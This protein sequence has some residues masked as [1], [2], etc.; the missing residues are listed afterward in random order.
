MNKKSTA[1]RSE[2]SNARKSSPD[3]NGEFGELPSV[4]EA[5]RRM[6]S[7]PGF[8]SSLS[9]EAK[10]AMLAYDGHENL[11]PGDYDA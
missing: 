5:R 4:A 2:R 9:P 7:K 6:L 11:G 3:L 1:A 10:A 8:I